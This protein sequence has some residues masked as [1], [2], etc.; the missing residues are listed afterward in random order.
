MNISAYLDPYENGHHTN[1]MTQAY[2]RPSWPPKGP[3][4]PYPTM[5]MTNDAVSLHH[6]YWDDVNTYQDILS[7][8]KNFVSFGVAGHEG[9]AGQ[10]THDSQPRVYPQDTHYVPETP[11]PPPQE[12]TYDS[13]HAWHVDTNQEYPETDGRQPH[14]DSHISN[15]QPPEP[16]P[17]LGNK[18]QD[19]FSGLA[20]DLKRWKTLPGENKARDVCTQD[21]R[22][23][24]VL[25]FLLTLV[26]SI[27]CLLLLVKLGAFVFKANR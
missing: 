27:S 15:N 7:G 9:L 26:L 1:P 6:R 14:L 19:S 23:I 3:S 13:K 24:I 17:S 8:E 12:Y 20:R 2:D 16:Q 22:V 11:P 21:N 10:P 18:L 4:R 5:D 25:L